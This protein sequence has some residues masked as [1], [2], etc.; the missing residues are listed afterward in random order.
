MFLSQKSLVLSQLII[1]QILCLW[2][3]CPIFSILKI[4]LTKNT[5]VCVPRSVYDALKYFTETLTPRT[6]SKI[7]LSHS[8]LSHSS[9][10]VNIF[11]KNFLLFVPAFGHVT[12]NNFIEF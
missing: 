5:R 12:V 4:V 7:I 9:F 6:F 8:F 3:I 11:S 2:Y 10:C 1:S